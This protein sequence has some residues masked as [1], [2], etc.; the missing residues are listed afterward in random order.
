M[1]ITSLKIERF[2]VWE[3]LNLP[4]ISRGLNVFFGPNEAGKTTLMQFIRTCLYGGGDED[5][6]R[7]IQMSLDGRRRRERRSGRFN[8][9]LLRLDPRRMNPN[10]AELD[11]KSNA[12]E[13]IRR[14][15][16]AG[17]RSEAISLNA[18]AAARD[19]SRYW[20]GGSA[21]LSSDFGDHR[22][23]RR[24][25]RRDAN[26][27]SAV[28]RKAGFVVS[29][30]LLNWSGRFYSL[31]GLK[32]AESL[33]VTGPDGTRVG[34][35]L[36][37]SL[38][39]NLDESTYNGVFAIGLDELQKLG[40]LNETEAAQMLYRL[41]VGVDRGA[42]VQ[43]FQQIVSE[44]NDLLDSKGRPSILE[45][46]L[47]ERDRARASAN[48]SATNLREYARL[49]EERRA[50]L[51]ATT[52]LQERLD[53]ATYQK[54]LRELATRVAPTW[55]ERDQARAD[56]LGMGDVPA[57]EQ[58]AVDECSVLIAAAD[59]TR[60]RIKKQK[61]AYLSKRDERD[62]IDVDPALDE[63]A[64]RVSILEDDLPRLEEIDS[65]VAKL[66][67]ELAELNKKLAEEDARV[68]SARNGKIMLTQSALDAIN[69]SIVASNMAPDA[70]FANQKEKENDPAGSAN[71]T[72][73]TL[74][75]KLAES[76]I[77]FKEVEDYKIP[78]K[79][80]RRRRIQL[81]K[82]REEF[83]LVGDR[84]EELVAKL[85]QGLTS[86]QQKNLTE[87]IERTGAL[88]TGLRRRIE[89]ERRV[90]E[91]GA[92]RKELERQN[93]ALADNQAIVGPPFYALCAGAFVGALL[94]ALALF[95]RVELVFGL[96]GLLATIGCL[97][98]KTT[99]ERRNRQK[100]EDNQRRLGL[101]TKQLD[102]AQ[103]EIK[104]LDEKFPAPST[105]TTATL[106]SR[107]QKA[108]NDLTFFE[109]LA[110]VEA[111]WRETTRLYRAHDARVK[112]AEGK[113]KIARKRWRSWLHSAYLPTS[114]KPVQVR[115][116]LARVGIAE[117]L[118]RQIEAVC[119]KIEYLGRERQGVVDRFN[120]AVALVEKYNV[121]ETLPA[122]ALP[123]L[124]ALL[125]EHAETL[126][127]R[128]ALLDEMNAIKKECRKE[129]ALRRRQVREIRRF[130]SGYNVKSKEELVAAVDRYS[131]YRRR[132]ANLDAVQQRLD[133]GIAGFCPEDEIG[134]LLL[135]AETR[136][137]LP[138]TI[139]NLNSRIEAFSAELKGKL[140][141][142]G[143]L[144]QQADAIAAKKGSIRRRFDAVA[145]DL[146]LAKM[147]ELW[148]SRAVSGQ[149]MEDIR[150]AYEKERQPETLR[151]ASRYLKRLTNGMYVNIWTPLGED[152]LYVDASNGETLDVAALSRGTRELLFIAIRL[153]LVVSFEKHGVQMPLIW[154]DVLVNFDYRRAST[155]AK[156]LVDFAKAGRQI[157]LFTCHEHICRLFL[158]LGVPICVLPTQTD[159]SKRRF[160]VLTPKKPLA[161]DAMTVDV[162][163]PVEG[164][165]NFS[166]EPEG[167][168]DEGS[169]V[170]EPVA[171][172][173]EKYSPKEEERTEYV[174]T[175]DAEHVS[176]VQLETAVLESPVRPYMNVDPSEVESLG[177]RIKERADVEVYVESEPTQDATISDVFVDKEP[178]EK[179]DV[180]DFVYSTKPVED[181]KG[182]YDAS[183][184]NVTFDGKD[185]ELRT[186]ADVSPT[187][188]SEHDK[189][190]G[191]F[192]VVDGRRKKTV[193]ETPF[194][195]EEGVDYVQVDPDADFIDA[196]GG[197]SNV[198]S[199]MKESGDDGSDDSFSDYM[200][201]DY[202]ESED[203][204]FSED[205]ESDFEEEYEDDESEEDDDEE[206]D[207][208]EYGDEEEE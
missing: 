164:G 116:L 73:V 136:A 189:V 142:S 57:V 55:D 108:K 143:R 86:R 70:L 15:L 14:F 203:E 32:I 30:G 145:A 97:L 159:P 28:E 197:W 29:D 141:L 199:A 200:S 61:A 2:G 167:Q 139:E 201:D 134:A 187:Y 130:L 114:L 104:D 56:L 160:R 185:A 100:L 35:Y 42:F 124:R 191:D 98:Y 137:D 157:F 152:A 174:M 89:V 72:V 194:D 148:Q 58:S 31:P 85:E 117:D 44:R 17:K 171:P 129:L 6:A 43:V 112:R 144:G 88:V 113:L 126:T 59:E 4:K 153:A 170:V 178:E 68:Q 50:V 48:E 165:P 155:A 166:E 205:D 168:D 82:F 156:L 83:K 75:N 154:D 151:E 138:V 20:I 162:S 105:Q 177:M 5:R 79:A 173:E 77:P 180:D 91:M 163:S 115:D 131:L 150:R 123:K 13:D 53:K 3:D 118:R 175:D 16:D 87:A 60:A 51:E 78:A 41:S 84:L 195:N 7:Y 94:F 9:E 202:E 22:L 198:L 65:K 149:I 63:L 67:E 38:T 99:V 81:Q 101:L 45:N 76:G 121:K 27:R 132:V 69:A 196:D 172:A 74:P 147:A 135:D 190:K 183:V 140:E 176:A 184:R 33:V 127:K 25:I 179:V 23:E 208:E 40:M 19:M 122:L 1:K 204:D 158:R 18:K 188:S 95:Q 64:P 92:Y 109:S 90:G 52:I 207:G 80:M 146:R 36:A 110:P 125:D 181:N 26:Y 47:S 8:Q 96:L 206:Y 186:L 62:L 24:Y 169:I 182:D 193:L 66:R 21:T 12:P 11:E 10:A 37:K 93:R 34:D 71:A 133:A 111:Q 46:L 103:S 161:A 49:L 102:Q 54:N 39:C 107:L 106:E 119:T 120:A 128:A 192:Q